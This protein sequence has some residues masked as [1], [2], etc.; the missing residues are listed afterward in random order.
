MAL[1]DELLKSNKLV[2]LVQKENFVGWIYSIDYENALVVTNDAWKQNV[3]GIP[4]NSFLVAASFDPE[5]FQPLQRWTGKS[6]FCVLLAHVN[7]LKMMI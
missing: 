2:S 5:N 3:K 1:L 6:F 7:Y 4:H